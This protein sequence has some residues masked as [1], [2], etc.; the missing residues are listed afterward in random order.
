MHH[1]AGLGFINTLILFLTFHSVGNGSC[2]CDSKNIYFAYGN[3]SKVIIKLRQFSNMLPTPQTSP[4]DPC[5]LT[6]STK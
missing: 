4:E 1:S 5:Q 2:S 6:Y 3:T